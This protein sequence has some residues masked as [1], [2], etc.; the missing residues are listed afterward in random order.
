MERRV[1]PGCAGVAAVE[2]PVGAVPEAHG[3]P[4]VDHELDRLGEGER[5]RGGQRHPV[6]SGIVDG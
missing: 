4:A 6:G 5:L 3:R 2:E 1:A